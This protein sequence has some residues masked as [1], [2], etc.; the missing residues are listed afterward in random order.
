VSYVPL[1]VWGLE[2]KVEGR[3]VEKRRPLNSFE[4]R[5]NC[6]F[7]SKKTKDERT[8]DATYFLGISFHSCDWRIGLRPR[9]CAEFTN[10]FYLENIIGKFGQERTQVEVYCRND[11]CINTQKIRW[12]KLCRD[13]KISKSLP[14]Q[15]T[16]NIFSVCGGKKARWREAVLRIHKRQAAAPI[17]GEYYSAWIKASSSSSSYF[18]PLFIFFPLFITVL[19]IKILYTMWRDIGEVEAEIVSEDLSFLFLFHQLG[20][21]FISLDLTRIRNKT[22]SWSKA[23]HEFFE[24]LYKVDLCWFCFINYAMNM[25]P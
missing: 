13:P 8:K 17:I 24:F 18:H 7:P 3:Y 16:E 5:S 4:V 10:L 11:I 19:W 12:R 6:V 23:N 9:N 21:K 20:M 15:S 22:F 14:W 2:G 25:L 1:C